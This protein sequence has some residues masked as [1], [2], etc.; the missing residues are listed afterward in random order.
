V[1]AGQIVPAVAIAFSRPNRSSTGAF[2]PSGAEMTDVGLFL[3][4][5]FVLLLVGMSVAPIRDR[6]ARR[7]ASGRERREN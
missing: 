4:A 5:T 6:L 7:L 2:G 1:A 3:L